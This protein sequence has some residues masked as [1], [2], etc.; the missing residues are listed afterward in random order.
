MSDG[1]LVE[2]EMQFFRHWFGVV[3][4]LVELRLRAP[5]DADSET[6]RCLAFELEHST[7]WPRLE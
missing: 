4:G 7:R 5:G 6:N 3:T 2:R 1:G